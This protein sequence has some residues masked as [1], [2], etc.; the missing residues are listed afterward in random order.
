MK[1]IL[2]I[3]YLA[4]LILS[5]KVSYLLLSNVTEVSFN[6]IIFICLQT[7]IIIGLLGIGGTILLKPKK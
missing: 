5:I 3:M 7:L 2:L 4:I 6:K 1:A